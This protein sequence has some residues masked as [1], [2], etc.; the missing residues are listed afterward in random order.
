MHLL[1]A[2]GLLLKRFLPPTYFALCGVMVTGSDLPHT[3]C[4][5][6]DDPDGCDCEQEIYYC[7][8]CIHHAAGW[9]AEID[10]AQLSRPAPVR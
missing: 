6:D 2:D 7:P 3:T 5:F 4:E 10:G 8:K 1:A 9:N